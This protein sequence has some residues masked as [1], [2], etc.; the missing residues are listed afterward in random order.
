M[1]TQPVVLKFTNEK[2]SAII[3]II[4]PWAEEVTVQP[5]STL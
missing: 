1:D 5:G 4:E 2:E 3:A